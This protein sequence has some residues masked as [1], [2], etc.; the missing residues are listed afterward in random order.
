MARIVSVGTHATDDPTKASL[1]FITAH[2]A[3]RAGE[4][5]AIVLIGEG[6]YLTKRNVAESVRGI[7]F[8][9][10]IEMIEKVVDIGIPVY[11]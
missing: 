9:P 8:P 10:L 2:G 1:P 7:G 11:V 6:A 5:A 4:E 3:S